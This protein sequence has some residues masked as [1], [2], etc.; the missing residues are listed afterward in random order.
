MSNNSL[1]HQ[2]LKQLLE[3]EKMLLTLIAEITEEQTAYCLP[4]LFSRTKFKKLE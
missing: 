2:I 1:F 3:L 4:N